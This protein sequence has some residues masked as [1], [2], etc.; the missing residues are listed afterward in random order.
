[1]IVWLC[2]GRCGSISNYFGSVWVG[3]GLICKIWVSLGRF[4]S[5]F[6]SVWFDLGRFGIGLIKNIY[7]F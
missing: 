4:G 5:V 2:L 3:V 1:V 7:P 6:R